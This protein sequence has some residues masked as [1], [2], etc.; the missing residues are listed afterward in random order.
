MKKILCLAAVFAACGFIAGC[1]DKEAAYEK[2]A[3]REYPVIESAP[4]EEIKE[5]IFEIDDMRDGLKLVINSEFM[6]EASE[7]S[8][9]L[10]S[11]DSKFYQIAAFS[12]LNKSDFKYHIVSETAIFDNISSLLILAASARENVC[13][14]VNYDRKNNKYIASLNVGYSGLGND[15][16]SINSVIYLK[17]APYYIDTTIRSPESEETVKTEM[18]SSGKFNEVSRIAIN[19]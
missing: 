14:F 8:L 18:F 12:A 16:K 4:G 9:Q 17:A 13:W 1:G 3:V 6:E 10:D 11:K 5:I 15:S 2:N 19:N 7:G